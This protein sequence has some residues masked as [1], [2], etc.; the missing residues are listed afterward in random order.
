MV[1]GGRLIRLRTHISLEFSFVGAFV[2]DGVENI[3]YFSNGTQSRGCNK[4][5]RDWFRVTNVEECCSSL[6]QVGTELQLH[7]AGIL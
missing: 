6:D 7:L 5:L 3:L 4:Q 2:V 1:V